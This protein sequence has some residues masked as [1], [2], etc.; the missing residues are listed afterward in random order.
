VREGAE[1]VELAEEEVGV[2]EVL[3]EGEKEEEQEQE[4]EEAR[5]WAVYGEEKSK[6]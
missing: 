3:E 2:Q 1:E 6:V 5:G 4:R